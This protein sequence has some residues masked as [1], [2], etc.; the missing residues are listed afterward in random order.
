MA[1]PVVAAQLDQAADQARR[2]GAAL[3]ERYSLRDLRTFA[4]VALGL[5]RMAWRTVEL[6]AAGVMR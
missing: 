6:D 2:Y 4:V 5:E 3:Q 1:L